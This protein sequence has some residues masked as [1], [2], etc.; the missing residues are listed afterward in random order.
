VSVATSLVMWRARRP[1]GLGAPRK[2]PDRRLMAGVF[3]ITVGFGVV[4]PLLGVSLVAI[5]VL[6]LLLV[7]RV[8]RLARA[9]GS[10]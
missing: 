7:R 4:F 3:A 2:E 6:D 9:L 8:P 5:L 10:R 1:K